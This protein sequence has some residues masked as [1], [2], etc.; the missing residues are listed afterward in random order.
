MKFQLVDESRES[1]VEEIRLGKK[2]ILV[3]KG[4]EHLSQDCFARMLDGIKRAIAKDKILI[5]EKGW[6]IQ[7]LKY[8]GEGE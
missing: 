5:L 1:V 3:F 4:D 7:V 8:Q 6:S 2:D